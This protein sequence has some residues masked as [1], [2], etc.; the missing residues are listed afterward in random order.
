MLT[1]ENAETQVGYQFWKHLAIY[2]VVVGGLTAFN[3]T[4]NPDRLWVI[5]VAVGWG[6]SLALHAAANWIPA[7]RRRMI[8]RVLERAERRE[9]RNRGRGSVDKAPQ[10][11]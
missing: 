4:R 1:H 2:V 7:C 3:L 9:S 8:S 5:W 6:V 11:R 10:A